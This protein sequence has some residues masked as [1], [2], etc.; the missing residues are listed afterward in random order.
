[1][2]KY[3]T[4]NI[5][6]ICSL[7]LMSLPIASFNSVSAQA[8]TS[9]VPSE[10]GVTHVVSATSQRD[11]W[12]WSVEAPLDKH[13]REAKAFLWIP[14][15]AE[16]VRG[17]FFGQQVI[18]EK[19]VFEDPHIRAACAREKL[20]IVFVVPGRIG[21]DDFDPK[22]A[23]EKGEGISKGEA[24]YNK[25][26]D[27]LADKSGYSELIHAP[28]ITIGHSG[29]ALWAWRMAYW[30]PDRCFG[31]IGL[32][33]APIGPPSHD[34]K[35][36]L[37]GVPALVITGQFETWDTDQGNIEHHWRWCRADI[38]A[39]RAKWKNFLGSVLVTPGAGHFNWGEN[40]ARYVSMFI[41]KAA[42]ARIPEGN[43]PRDQPP[44][45]KQLNEKCGWL[46]D[47]TLTTP[48]NFNSASFD[49][50]KGD[51]T[52]AFWHLDEELARANEAFGQTHGKKLQLVTP[53]D[54]NGDP[55]KP[56]WI[57]T[58]ELKP[59]ADGVTY[60]VKASFV[61]ETP[62]VFTYP[63]PPHVI[64]HVDTNK[65]GSIKFRLIGG[66]AGGGEQVDATT[67]RVTYDRF[68]L[69]K[70]QP[71]LMIMA[72]HPG[73][74]DYLY[75]EQPFTIKLPKFNK[76]GKDQGISF[77]A[78]PNQKVG[79]GPMTLSA[80]SNSGDKDLAVRFCAIEGPI[81]IDGNKVSFTEIPPRT[82]FPIQVT[83]AAYQWGRAVEPKVKSAET[84]YQSFLIEK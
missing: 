21:Y 47:N 80:K 43:P 4:T 77:D 48:S 3:I 28:F 2:R 33:A 11:V 82:K 56:G 26:I 36:Q 24:T 20:A 22:K 15:G 19:A 40:T 17:I 70:K 74:D 64:D 68:T 75:A 72:F 5:K 31:V 10:G 62:E 67:F 34:S 63:N 65:S 73:D 39:W 69:A 46:T 35:A 45:L 55:V 53:I 76:E 42:Q 25:I 84:V 32:R 71:G 54:K 37:S 13:K 8:K 16:R 38:L 52:M 58:A 51:P 29:G 1:L 18:L 12:Q 30:Q 49:H 61:K 79:S 14:P 27:D 78:I 7:V 81:T 83:I 6:T 60:K 44:V 66:W 59:E 57:S 41:E 50:F 9:S 23:Q